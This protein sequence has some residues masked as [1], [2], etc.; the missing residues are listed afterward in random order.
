MK[1]YDKGSVS[2]VNISFK[3]NNKYKKLEGNITKKDFKKELILFAILNNESTKVGDH[4]KI[5]LYKIGKKSNK[6]VTTVHKKSISKSD[7]N[8]ESIYMIVPIDNVLK[9]G[10]YEYHIEDMNGEISIYQFC[11]GK[12]KKALPIV[13]ASVIVPIF[14]F[15]TVWFGIKILN[16][17]YGSNIVKKQNG[18]LEA[19]GEA[20]LTIDDIK[21]KERDE[22]Q[23]ILNENTK[24]TVVEP[25]IL[26]TSTIISNQEGIISDISIKTAE[27]VSYDLTTSINFYKEE[28]ASLINNESRKV[29]SEV[30]SYYDIKYVFDLIEDK[31]II[32]LNAV[33]NNK[34]AT[35]LKITLYNTEEEMLYETKT[36]DIKGTSIQIILNEKLTDEP[37]LYRLLLYNDN[38]DELYNIYSPMLL[39][40]RFKSENYCQYVLLDSEG[41]ELFVSPLT[42]PGTILNSISLNKKL[43]VGSYDVTLRYSFYNKEKVFFHNYDEPL[44]LKVVS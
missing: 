34:E 37:V 2:L 16:N 26:T 22:T 7:K 25:D 18:P 4:Y 27:A 40:E 15:T 44:T 12:K 39:I 32:N 21:D 1:I 3:E 19:S 38:N 31:E 11:V 20:G 6:L 13:L 29:I 33:I 28:K 8:P 14:I 24:K 36:I 30:F 42:S 9:N 23:K 41:N 43:P 35:K 10:I 5:E 17:N